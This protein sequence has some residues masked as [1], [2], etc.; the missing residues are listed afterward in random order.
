MINVIPVST[1]T[2]SITLSVP[3]VMVLSAFI[4]KEGKWKEQLI[5]GGLAYIF[6]FLY[7]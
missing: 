6:V 4:Y 1:V 3:F 7:Y 5:F 2:L